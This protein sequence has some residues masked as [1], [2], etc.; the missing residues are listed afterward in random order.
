MGLDYMYQAKYD[1]TVDTLSMQNNVKRILQNSAFKRSL[2]RDSYQP[3]ALLG[4]PKAVPENSLA[5]PKADELQL[6]ETLTFLKSESALKLLNLTKRA[7]EITNGS[8][9]TEIVVDETKKNI[10]AA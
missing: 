1:S 9:I 8:E 6:N 7:E 4:T 3:S 5:I 2:A 10:F